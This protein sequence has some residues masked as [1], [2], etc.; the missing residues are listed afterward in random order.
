MPGGR[1]RRNLTNPN[2]LGP[3]LVQ[4]REISTII[5]YYVQSL[6]VR[7]KLSGYVSCLFYFR[8]TT[9]PL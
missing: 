6:Q 1:L 4:I 3:E 8:K 7:L 2:S 5:D 9:L